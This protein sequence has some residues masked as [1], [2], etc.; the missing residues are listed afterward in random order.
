MAVMVEIAGWLLEQGWREEVGGHGGGEEL[1]G[2]Q[3][4][5]AR[6]GEVVEFNGQDDF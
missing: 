5:A 2:H 4:R 1:E 6:G 3:V